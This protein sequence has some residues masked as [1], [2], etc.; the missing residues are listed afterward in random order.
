ML[1][2]GEALADGLSLFETH[3]ALQMQALQ[4]IVLEDI[5]DA[6]LEEADLPEDEF[7]VQLLAYFLPD[8]I[9]LSQGR[10]L[11]S[12]SDE[13]KYAVEAVGCT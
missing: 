9:E 5:G 1:T 8:L 13:V 4:L 6:V 7:E 11:W 2:G 12:E 3:L 10:P